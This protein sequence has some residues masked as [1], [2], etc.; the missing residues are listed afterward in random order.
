MLDIVGTLIWRFVTDTEY[1]FVI[2]TDVRYVN[3]FCWNN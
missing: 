3:I 1:Q 2:Y